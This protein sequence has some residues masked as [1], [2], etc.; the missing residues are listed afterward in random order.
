M[1][2]IL[3]ILC[4]IPR[5]FD[6][7]CWVMIKI[8][9]V[10][11]KETLSYDESWA[12]VMEKIPWVIWK[13]GGKK[14]C[15]RIRWTSLVSAKCKDWLRHI[16]TDMITIKLIVT[17]DRPSTLWGKRLQCIFNGSLRLR[18]VTNCASLHQKTPTDQRYKKPKGH[19][20]PWMKSALSCHPIEKVK[21]L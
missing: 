18:I 19:K 11:G 5:G 13:S 15:I 9:W 20:S 16:S 1:G 3:G 4:E 7:N 2:K 10:M 6:E 12:W 17:L 8:P 14:P 21:G